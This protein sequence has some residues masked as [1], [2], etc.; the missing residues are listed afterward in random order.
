MNARKSVRK[1][2][3]LEEDTHLLQLIDKHGTNGCW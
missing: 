2:W 1:P 3:T